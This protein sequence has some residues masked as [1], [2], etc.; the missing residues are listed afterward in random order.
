MAPDS[1]PHKATLAASRPLAEETA[2]AAH[3]MALGAARAARAARA[4]VGLLMLANGASAF[5]RL[6]GPYTVDLQSVD[7][8]EDQGRN[9]LVY[10]TRLHKKSAM[11]YEYSGPWRWPFDLDDD[12]WHVRLEAERWGSRG[13]GKNALSFDSKKPCSDALSLVGDMFRGIAEAAGFAPTCPVPKGNYTVKNWVVKL[14]LPFKELP[15]GT[16]SIDVVFSYKGERVGCMRVKVDVTE[17]N[18]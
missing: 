12:N 11:E 10:T 13:W 6:G 2:N 9:L 5:L 8:C 7:R 15:Y 3:A 1:R 17:K 18:S 16:Y 14:Q 4:A